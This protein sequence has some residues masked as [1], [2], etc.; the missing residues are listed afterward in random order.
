M[1]RQAFRIDRL[2]FMRGTHGD[3]IALVDYTNTGTGEVTIGRAVYQAQ[4]D[5]DDYWCP[6]GV[7]YWEGILALL[8]ACKNG[9]QAA[10][11][12]IESEEGSQ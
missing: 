2:S 9:I 4:S 11:E 10:I 5:G 6:D 7:E 12:R 8:D 1:K 3:V